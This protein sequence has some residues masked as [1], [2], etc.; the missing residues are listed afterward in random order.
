LQ[1][2]TLQSLDRRWNNTP[3]L[4]QSSVHARGIAPYCR[5]A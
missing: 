4:F 1:I 5:P 3:V 2:D